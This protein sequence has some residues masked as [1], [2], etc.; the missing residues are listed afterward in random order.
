MV[1]EAIHHNADVLGRYA[2]HAF[3]VMP[4]HVHLLLSPRISVPQ[5]TRALK[6]YTAKRANQALALTGN[7]FWQRESYDHL[8][9]NQ[10]EWERVKFYI[11]QNPVRAGLVKEAGQY[12]WSSAGWATGRSLAD[13]E[14]HPTL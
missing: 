7:P 4:N 10:A 1:V 6:G 13:L 11:E 8:V 2:L 5:I 9:R 3:V 14:V 12:C